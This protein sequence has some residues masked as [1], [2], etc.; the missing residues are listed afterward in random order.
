MSAS[1]Q[2][3]NKTKLSPGQ[4]EA[5]VVLLTDED[6]AVYR[7]VRQKLL[8]HGQQAS[9]CLQ[10]HL[11]SSDAVLRRRAR[12][13]VN[14]LARQSADNAFLGFCLTHGEDFDLEEAIWLM[15][16]TRYPEANAEAYAALL[17][18]FA[19]E[20]RERIDF[21]ARPAEILRV[22]N[23]YLFDDLGF[24]GNQ[25]EYYDPEN[26]YLNRVVDRRLGNPISLCVI[27]LQ[28]ARR[29]HLPVAGIGM[30]GHFLCRF[31][32]STEEI[33]IDAFNRGKLLTKAECVRYLVQSNGGFS[34]GFL[35][36]VT[37]K[38]ILQRI[39]ANLLQIHSEL[40]DEEEAA[41][42]Q[43]YIVALSR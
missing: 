6:P 38:R 42:I 37:P 30:P 1:L 24:A 10:A 16:R 28:V 12:E 22:I 11:L 21:G 25:G 29:L 35:A 19:G 15:A 34:D 23:H 41:R 26:S 33:F 8:S 7:T 36:P 9:Q 31:Q 14:Y 2:P 18:D 5:L 13:L 3:K 20:L 17:D 32:S 27:Y 4:L 43:R 39:C 40:K